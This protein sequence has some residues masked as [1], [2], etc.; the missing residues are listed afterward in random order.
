MAVDAHHLLERKLFPNKGYYLDNGASLCGDCHLQAER[1]DLSVEQ[2][3]SL[4]GVK[5]LVLPPDFDSSLIY[6][7]GG[8]KF[9]G[10]F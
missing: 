9:K 7:N 4:C 10:I 3:R 6:A 5:N 8:I 2:L 1:T